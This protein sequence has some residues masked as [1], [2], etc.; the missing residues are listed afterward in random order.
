MTERERGGLRVV[1][2]DGVGRP[3]R[4]RGLAEWLRDAAPAR[5]RGAVTIALVDDDAMRR[6]NREFAGRDKA[7][8]VLSFPAG[9]R[10]AQ[11]P[12]RTEAPR[13]AEAPPDIR[14]PR[15]IGPPRRSAPFLGDIVIATGV[16]RHQARA[17]GHAYL[18]ELR[19]LALHGLLHLLGHDHETDD[20][21]MARLEARLRRRGGLTAG[22]IER[23]DRS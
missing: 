5:A 23:A 6:L 9:D 15:H 17:A 2:V 22:V 19:V 16:A 4:V 1:V 11:A 13:E 12:R 18:Q 14:K 20:G 7:T 10:G 21:K 3:A 8:D